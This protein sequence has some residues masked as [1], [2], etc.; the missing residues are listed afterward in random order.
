MYKKKNTSALPVRIT[1]A[2]NCFYENAFGIL[3]QIMIKSQFESIHSKYYLNIDLLNH[4]DIKIQNKSLPFQSIYVCSQLYHF[5]VTRIF[6]FFYV[7]MDTPSNN[8]S[9]SCSYIQYQRI[10]LLGPLHKKIGFEAIHCLLYIFKLFLINHYIQKIQFIFH[11][12]FLNLGI[13]KKL[14][15]KPPEAPINTLHVWVNL[16]VKIQYKILN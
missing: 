16:N 11:T 13:M 10:R 9:V 14:I 1:M 3:I 12:T 2:I 8:V 7:V 15:L 5:R 6:L 4:I